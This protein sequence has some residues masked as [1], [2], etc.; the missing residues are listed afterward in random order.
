MERE[1]NFN[2]LEQEKSAITISDLID[3]ERQL[4]KKY[5][6]LITEQKKYGGNYLTSH[7]KIWD[8]WVYEIPPGTKTE[9]AV[10]FLKQHI[11]GDVLIDLGAG[12]HDAMKDLSTKLEAKAYVGVDQ[13]QSFKKP[14][15][16]GE[17]NISY[18]EKDINNT[19]LIK[20]ESDMLKFVGLTRDS[21]GS[22]VLN[23]IDQYV[24]KSNDYNLALVN[25]I[26]RATHSG[27]IIFGVNSEDIQHHLAEIAAQK[28]SVLEKPNLDFSYFPP[29]SFIFIKK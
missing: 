10:A 3:P 21:S 6:A 2:R 26:V 28:D 27:G 24:I 7:S 15:D 29:H 4:P 16:L 12:Q 17:T 18:E 8:D 20:V 1:K 11:S 25:E 14:Q 23:G 22:F 9:Q 19:H 5:Q 13:Y